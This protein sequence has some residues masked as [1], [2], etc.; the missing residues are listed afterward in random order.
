[1]DELTQFAIPSILIPL[2]FAHQDEQ[3]QNAEAMKKLGGA[4]VIE[5]KQ[6]SPQLLLQSIDETKQKLSEIRILLSKSV[7]PMQSSELL[8]AIVKDVH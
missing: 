8:Y 2:P 4:V 1:M 7:T 5:Q 6:L 3:R